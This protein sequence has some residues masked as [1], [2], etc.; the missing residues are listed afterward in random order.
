[1]ERDRAYL[2]DMLQARATRWSI[3]VIE[4]AATLRPTA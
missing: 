4:S 2:L 1:M 3:R